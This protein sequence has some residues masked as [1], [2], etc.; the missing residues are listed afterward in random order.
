MAT[1]VWSCSFLRRKSP[2]CSTCRTD[3]AYGDTGCKLIATPSWGHVRIMGDVWRNHAA[4]AFFS[5]FSLLYI[6]IT[7]YHKTSVRSDTVDG[8]DA[9]VREAGVPFGS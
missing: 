4:G 3:A 1:S 8:N 5:I 7:L 2:G 9:Q 6:Y